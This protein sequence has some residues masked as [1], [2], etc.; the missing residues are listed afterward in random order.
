MFMG[1]E[2][3]FCKIKKFL[4]IGYSTTCIY[5]T[6]LNCTLKMITIVIFMRILPLKIFLKEKEKLAKDFLFRSPTVHITSK[7]DQ[8]QS[9][10]FENHLVPTFL[11][12]NPSGR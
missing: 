3:Q 5:L 11:I 2:F 8:F 1:T 4:K 12:H 10:G 7:D 6:L 9:Q